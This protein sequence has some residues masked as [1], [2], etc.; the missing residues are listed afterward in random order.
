MNELSNGLNQPNK[1]LFFEIWRKVKAGLSL[2]GE[3][4]LI[5]KIMLEHKE[6]HNTWEFADILEEVEY[7]PNTEVNPFMH[8][9]V[10]TIIENQLARDEPKGIRKIFK[11]MMTQEKDRHQVIHRIGAALTEE[12]WEMMKERRPFDETNYFKSLKSDD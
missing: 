8:I 12:M 6:Y 10:H 11:E 4:R 3:A 7:D 2:K 1:K 9:T 5:G